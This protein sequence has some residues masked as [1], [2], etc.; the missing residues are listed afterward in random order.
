M[1]IEYFPDLPQIPSELLLSIDEIY[2]LR[3][4]SISSEHNNT[5]GYNY[6]K[7][8]VNTE[9]EEWLR[10]LFPYCDCFEYQ[11]I[12]NGLRGHKDVARL[13]CYNY[14]V[15]GSNATTTWYADDQETI[16][17]SEMIKDNQWH[18]IDVQ[19]F[20]SVKGVTDIRYTITVYK[21]LDTSLK[22]NYNVR[23]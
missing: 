20:H 8:P 22:E 13:T 10:P 6:Q 9:L 4:N 21:K 16:L 15:D 3:D 14:L 19:V 2:A 11:M 7:F 1:L 12:K 18:K 23:F 5:R 17:H